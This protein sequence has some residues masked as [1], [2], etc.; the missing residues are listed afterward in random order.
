ME[1]ETPDEGESE[2]RKNELGKW[3]TYDWGQFG[4]EHYMPVLAE[5]DEEDEEF[6]L[7]DGDAPSGAALQTVDASKVHQR[8]GL[9]WAGI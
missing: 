3:L 9:A 6:D 5:A 1:F 7:E 4:I 2:N 8:E